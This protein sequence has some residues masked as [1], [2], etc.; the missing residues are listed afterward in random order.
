MTVTP[1][2]QNGRLAGDYLAAAS[3][4]VGS[5]QAQQAISYQ[6]D[7]YIIPLRDAV[8]AAGMQAGNALVSNLNTAHSRSS[9]TIDLAGVMS[10]RMLLEASGAD[11]LAAVNWLEGSERPVGTA[12][13]ISREANP[14]VTVG[15]GDRPLTIHT[16]DQVKVT[17]ST[18]AQIDGLW[19]PAIVVN[20]ALGQFRLNGAD[21][22]AAVGTGAGAVAITRP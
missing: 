1:T 13:T 17:G 6:N 21:T 11:V 10:F 19:F 14:L 4:V 16:G 18:W 20:A 12:L 8:V 3:N 7:A 2:S 5:A 9:D 15:I 22:T